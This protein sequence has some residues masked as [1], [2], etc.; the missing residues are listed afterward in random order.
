[1]NAIVGDN[2][3]ITNAMDAKFNS[4]IAV[5]E[6]W[7]QQKY[8]DFYDDVDKYNSKPELLNAKIKNFLLKDGTKIY[9]TYNRKMYYLINKSSLPKEIQE[10]LVGGDTTE[11]SQYIRLQD[12][13]GVTSDLKI[14]YFGQDG[15]EGKVYGKTEDL[16]VDPTLPAKE[17]SGNEILSGVVKSALSELGINVE[18]DITIGDL[19]GLKNLTID[20][21][22][23]DITTLA[24]I[25]EIRNL[26][27]LV[28]K[29]LTQLP[30]LDG[31]ES[32][33]LLQSVYFDNCILTEE[34]GYDKLATMIDLN[35]LYF[36]FDSSKEE[37]VLNEEVE[38]IA[39]GLSKAT[40]L[41]NL[42]YFGMF[43]NYNYLNCSLFDFDTKGEKGKFSYVPEDARSNLKDISSFSKFSKNIKNSIKYIYLNENNLINI[44]VLKDFSNLV[45][46]V[47]CGNT[48]L[49]SLDGLENHTTI[50]YLISQYC[51]ISTLSG[52]KGCS[53]LT[54]IIINN[55]QLKDLKELSSINLSVLYCKDN[56]LSDISSVKNCPNLT[57]VNFEN[58]TDKTENGEYSLV[59][60]SSLKYCLKIVE[61]YLDGN[62]M[63]DKEFLVTQ[64]FKEMLKRCGSNYSLSSEYSLLFLDGAK[65]DFLNYGLTDD[66]LKL[67]TGNE[68][69]KG[70][71]LGG[72]KLLTNDVINEVLGSLSNLESVDLSGCSQV[73]SIEFTKNLNNIVD[74]NLIG[75]EV[76]DLSLL[77]TKSLEKDGIK[78]KL[79]SLYIDNSN[80]DIA[81][82]QNLIN[83]VSENY[84]KQNR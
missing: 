71:R 2:G 43:G 70:I 32:L 36:R 72:N 24:G 64:D 38:K 55:N 1:M 74:L 10:Q 83:K 35:K 45:E 6:E 51:G 69:V 61:C 60:I 77:E 49:T 23:T 5:L 21:S 26:K 31:I 25:S 19:A 62:T 27:N 22:K 33:S 37:D 13:Y 73:T 52:L 15:I 76:T 53:G 42:E 8:V 63:L 59:E 11:Y 58:N 50:N 12:V 29:D 75:T 9:V 39:S 16:E 84:T 30:N 79:G 56:K 7:V 20:G 80:I 46:V 28:L 18:G 68:N 67:L 40:L 3:V 34:D 47:L 4:G 81:N 54:N 41:T 48:N 82:I 57:Y 14:Y 17:L 65:Q 66:N 78:F 44:D